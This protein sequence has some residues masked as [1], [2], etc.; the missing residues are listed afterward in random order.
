[1]G[2]KSRQEQ[3]AENL[4]SKIGGMQTSIDNP[5]AYYKLKST[6][7]ETSILDKRTEDIFNTE[8]T[9]LRSLL[10]QRRMEDLRGIAQRLVNQGIAGGTREALQQRVASQY[11]G[12][13]QQGLSQLLSQKMQQQMQN[14]LT[15]QQSKQV[16]DQLM[17]SLLGN[18]ANVDLS[19]IKNQMAK[20]QMQQQLLGFFDDTTWLDDVLAVAN[21]VGGLAG[22]IMTG[23][24]YSK[25]LQLLIKQ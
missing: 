12:Q 5:F 16:Y 19:N 21:T 20:Y 15:S 6:P 9:N 2:L 24:A 17:M 1:M 23:G 8:I 7:L 14:L 13:E 10:N 18:K 22:N 3:E 25:L 11:A 4:Y